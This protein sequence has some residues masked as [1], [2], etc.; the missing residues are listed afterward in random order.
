[1]YQRPS[2]FLEIVLK[3]LLFNLQLLMFCYML[4][5]YITLFHNH[6]NIVCTFIF[7]YSYL[8]LCHLFLDWVSCSTLCPSLDNRA[9]SKLESSL[10]SDCYVV[11][12]QVIELWNVSRGVSPSLA[13]FLFYETKLVSPF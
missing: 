11:A 10:H 7:S 1:M 5:V 8:A 2:Q 4:W 12:T 13:K 3:L 6:S 9:T